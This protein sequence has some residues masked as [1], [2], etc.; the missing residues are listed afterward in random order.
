[1]SRDTIWL[2]GKDSEWSWQMVGAIAVIVSL[3]F[4]LRQVHLAR[5]SN[6]LETPHAMDVRWRSPAH[7]EAKAQVCANYRGA[8]RGL[9]DWDPVRTLNPSDQAD[10]E[11]AAKRLDARSYVRNSAVAPGRGRRM[12]VGWRVPF[13]G[14]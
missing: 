8:L 5:M 14:P 2:I 7:N 13:P 12:L 10:N 4:V 6:M 9:G 3:V 11:H 1:M